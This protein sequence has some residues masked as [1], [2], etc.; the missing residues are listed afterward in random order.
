MKK[1]IFVIGALLLAAVFMSG[2]V[3]ET[4]DPVLGIWHTEEQMVSPNNA[5]IDSHFLVFNADGTG[6][7]LA[8]FADDLASGKLEY[9]WKNVGNGIYEATVS[10]TKGTGLPAVIKVTLKDGK[11][12]QEIPAGTVEY[13]AEPVAEYIEGLW[14]SHAGD[15]LDH[16]DIKS[17]L[18]FAADGTGHSL[19]YGPAVMD[20][21]D[22]YSAA[23]TWTEKDGVLTITGERGY[24]DEILVKDGLLYFEG[25]EAFH[26][27]VV[28]DHLIGLWMSEEPYV[29]DGVAYDIVTMIRSDGT[30]VELWTIPDSH[31][32]SERFAFTWEMTTAYTC[33]AV[34]EDGEVWLFTI[35]RLQLFDGDTRYNKVGFD[36]LREYA[37]KAA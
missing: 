10:D 2:C 8:G 20:I 36:T 1:T 30:G 15:Y 26:P 21:E 12:Y 27:Y 6:F 19:T 32:A 7:S 5:L 13:H 3:A 35:D 31:K 9:T 11:L 34:Y 18:Y 33:K 25:V 4:D 14:I 29:E 22:V 24:Q 16:E 17:M 37:N 23:F 28:T